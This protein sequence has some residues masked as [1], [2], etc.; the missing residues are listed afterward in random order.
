MAA[1]GYQGGMAACGILIAFGLARAAAA[2]GIGRAGRLLML[3]ALGHAVMASYPSLAHR[4]EAALIALALADPA[5]GSTPPA[6]ALST[7]AIFAKPPLGYGLS[8]L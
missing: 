6:L 1:L 4:C 8:A 7:A 5:R 2:T 3:A